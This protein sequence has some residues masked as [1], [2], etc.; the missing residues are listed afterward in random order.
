MPL[1]SSFRCV[2][3]ASALL[4]FTGGLLAGCSSPNPTTAGT[5]E[6][7]APTTATRGPGTRADSLGGIP[8]HRFGEPL[9]A[10]AGIVLSPNQDPAA[11]VKTYYYPDGKGEPGW[12]GKR[13][14][15]APY[16]IPSFYFFRDGK[17]VAFQTIAYKDL[18][19]ALSE[20]ARFLFGPAGPGRTWRGEQVL[21][22][23]RLSVEDLGP[24]LILNV[25]S[26]DFVRAQAAEKDARLKAENAQ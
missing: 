12:F 3:A 19:D 26:Q 18:R 10:F 11:G 6:A 17:F 13:H 20:Q 15:E 9:S 8:G 5:T 25:Q 16:D 1:Q 2:F 22:F 24:A 4:T 21:A 7:A 14:R 23:Y